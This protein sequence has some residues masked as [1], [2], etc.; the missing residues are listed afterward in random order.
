[1]L[2]MVAVTYDGAHS[3]ERALSDMRASRDDE[4]LSEVG[5]LE[6]DRDGRYSV[7]AKNPKVGE[8]KAGAG[9]A[10]GGVTGLFLGAIG[11]PFGLLLWGSIGALAGAGIGASAESAFKPTADELKASLPP[12]ASMLVLVGESSELDTFV[13]ATGASDDQ[14]LR[15]PLTSDQAR[16][17]DE[18]SRG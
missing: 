12:D 5:M 9:A 4:W 6:H 14:I 16:E 3:A 15:A 1:M 11:G 13:A 17:L 18:A 10:I 8:G 7:K 2:E